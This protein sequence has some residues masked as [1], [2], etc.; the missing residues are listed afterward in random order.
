MEAPIVL[1]KPSSVRAYLLAHEFSPT[2]SLGQNFLV[3]QN[4]RDL[5][6]RASGVAEGER[7]IEIGPGL[8][9]MTEG[10]L[11]AG[12]RI[13]AVE[14]DHRLCAH[15]KKQFP[16]AGERLRIHA[17]D[18]TRTDWSALL[19]PRPV[20]VV[21][22]LPYSVG[23]RVLYDLAAPGVCPRSITVMVQSDVAE[24]LTARPGTKNWGVL[25]IRMA[26]HYTATTVHQVAGSCFVPPPRVGSSV[27]H[28]E[29]RETPLVELSNPSRFEQIIKFAFTRRRKQLQRILKECDLISNDLDEQV[30]HD[31]GLK[32]TARP[33]ELTL[34]E[35]AMITNF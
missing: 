14:I 19:A 2:K 21:S 13:D 31:M 27:V 34:E 26:V 23:S 10:L 20:R 4:V 1:T 16:E 6:V 17:Q 28:L 32:S 7:V 35:W 3:D 8:G 11:A 15:L 22:N 24:R 18:A 30:L 33:G 12:A 5:I 29:R 9:V 25:G